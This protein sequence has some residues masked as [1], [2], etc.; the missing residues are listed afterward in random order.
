MNNQTAFRTHLMS[1]KDKLFRYA[2]Y[3]LGDAADAEDA[4]QEV[5]V[6]LWNAMESGRIDNCGH[7][8][9]RTMHNYCVDLLRKRRRTS[10]RNVALREDSDDAAMAWSAHGADPSAEMDCRSLGTRIDR[11]V[12]GLPETLRSVFLMYEVNGLK[13]REIAA[14][15]CL[16]INSVKVHLLRARRM[17]QEELKHEN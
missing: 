1:N 17:L 8:L 5:F 13:Y 14:H 6:R 12:H 4:I 7:W 16:P 11:A 9:M 10:D 2:R 3:T 15:L